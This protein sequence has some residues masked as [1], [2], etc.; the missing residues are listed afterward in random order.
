MTNITEEKKALRAHFKNLRAGLDTKELSRRICENALSFEALSN[1]RTV[2]LYASKGSEAD[3]TSLLPVL[4]KMGKTVGFPRCIDSENMVFHKVSDISELTKGYF[5]LR[6][7]DPALPII[8]KE[9]TGKD[10]LCLVPALAFDRRGY[11]L[12]YGGGYYDRFLSGFSGKTAGITFNGCLTDFIPADAHDI[13]TDYII[14]E[15]Q[16]TKTIE[17]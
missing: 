11:R 6:E 12:G 1:A 16:V 2:L 7:P 8:K 15:S 5:G 14:T 3:I 10:T 4:T 9:D 13:K 17:D